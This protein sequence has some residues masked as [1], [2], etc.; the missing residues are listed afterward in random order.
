M[1]KSVFSNFLKQ[2]S[3]TKAR[4]LKRGTQLCAFQS[5]F[6]ILSFF[7]KN[8]P[9]KAKSSTTFKE[10]NGYKELLKNTFSYFFFFED[11]K[12]RNKYLERAQKK[13]F[14]LLLAACNS[15]NLVKIHSNYWNMLGE[16]SIFKQNW[17]TGFHAL[18][19]FFLLPSNLSFSKHLRKG[20][21]W[22]ENKSNHF[23]FLLFWHQIRNHFPLFHW[24]KINLLQRKTI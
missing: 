12:R 9:K 23:S 5:F 24:F 6:T 7:N 3:H 4:K 2:D 16:F 18:L 11:Q 10:S 22:L 1:Q 15:L 20:D 8:L 21:T 17:P 19:F 14:Y 13:Y